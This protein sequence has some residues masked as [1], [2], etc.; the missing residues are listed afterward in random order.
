MGFLGGKR[1]A[2]MAPSVEKP[3]A[4]TASSAHCAKTGTPGRA[5]RL[6]TNRSSPPAARAKETAHMYQDSQAASL[7]LL[8]L[9]PR[10]GSTRDG[11][12]LLDSSHASST[13]DPA[14]SA[15]E[16]FVTELVP[17]DPQNR[18]IH[19]S[20]R[21]GFSPKFALTALSEVRPLLVLGET[22]PVVYRATPARSEDWQNQC[23]PHELGQPSRKA[24]AAV[25][26]GRD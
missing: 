21:K 20:A 14:H 1:G 12:L 13:A 5:S 11:S 17:N 15:N 7:G 24:G 22:S 18:P 2:T 4:I 8:A 10:L 6:R 9:V 3:T 26:P 25:E 19:S 23:S 16:P